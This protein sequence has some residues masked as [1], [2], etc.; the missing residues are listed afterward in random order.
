MQNTRKPRKPVKYFPP[1]EGE[2]V[3]VEAGR[4]WDISL[5]FIIFIIS[6]GPSRRVDSGSHDAL[7]VPQKSEPRLI[8]D[9]CPSTGHSVKLCPLLVA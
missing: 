2:D 3:S 6:P 7:G 8:H 5:L 1:H 9:V 4:P